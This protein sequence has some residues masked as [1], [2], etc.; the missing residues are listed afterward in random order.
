[1]GG[2]QSSK[3]I[4]GAGHRMKPK[5]SRQKLLQSNYSVYW[6]LKPEQPDKYHKR[7]RFDKF[8]ELPEVTK[9]VWSFDLAEY[10]MVLAAALADHGVHLWDLLMDPPELKVTIKAHKAHVWAV[11]FSPNE[12]ALATGSDDKTVRIW[13]A[14]T[15]M[16][17]QVLEA[18]TEGIRCLAFSLDG[19]L[20]SGGMDSQICMWE[21][22]SSIPSAQWKA[23]EG[24]VH[25]IA[26][27]KNH[28]SE[29][30]TLALSVG[31][32][33]SVAGWHVEAGIY[34]P[35]GRFAG[36]GGKGVLCI[37][38]HTV[39][40]NWCACGNEDGAVWVWNFSQPD[41]D[42]RNEEQLEVEGSVKLI[43]H[44]QGVRTLAFT[45]DGV[46][47]ASGSTDGI[48]RVWD[49]RA[50]CE[51]G[52]EV[53]CLCV[54][55]AHDSWVTELRFE[56]GDRGMVTCSSDGLV[57]HWV[58][59]NRVKKIKRKVPKL[60]QLLQL[61]AAEDVEPL[62]FDKQLKGWRVDPNYEDPVPVEDEP[63][64]PGRNLRNFTSHTLEAADEDEPYREL[65][66]LFLGDDYESDEDDE[67]TDSEEAQENPA[68][69]DA[70]PQQGDGAGLPSAEALEMQANRPPE[71]RRPPQ[72]LPHPPAQ[73]PPGSVPQPRSEAA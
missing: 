70:G 54:F 64:S 36:G 48:V 1:M 49:I 11:V 47:L 28:Q 37:A 13:V 32:D 38:Q 72:Q 35:L 30:Q 22:Q 12:L 65:H 26:F 14:E 43:G 41:F 58:A 66:K 60:S 71:P 25:S 50:M 39:E 17:L 27:V 61:P 68:L 33:G 45:P 2:T 6:S 55:K 46:L 53:C 73:D 20:L 23:H 8:R 4:I 59:P 29:N 21:Y 67:D 7:K 63:I 40:D 52:H 56:G 34:Q 10:T 42:S 15:G 31:A 16:P 9:P 24:H 19:L 3:N 62:V 18:H 69:A 51:D 57:K 5:L 44:K